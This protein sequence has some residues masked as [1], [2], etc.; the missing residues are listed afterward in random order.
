MGRDTG[1][2]RALA[3]PAR[4]ASGWPRSYTGLASRWLLGAGE[5]ARGVLAF[6]LITLGVLVSRFDM[7]RTV[8]R[9]RIRTQIARAGVQLLPMVLFLATALG[10]VVIGQTVALLSQVGAQHLI[11]TVMVTAVVREL[12]PL[13]AAFVVL[14]RIGTATVIDLGSSRALGEIE[15]LEALGIDPIHYL[16]VPRVVGM[17]LATF[18]LTVYFIMAAL[19]CG[20]LFAFIQDVPIKPGEYF[21]Q[22]A[23]AL[24]WPDFGLLLLKPLAFGSVIAVV[25]CYQG[26][27]RPLELREV[28]R[29]T[30]TAV[31]ASTIACVLLDVGFILVYLLV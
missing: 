2:R 22:L 5:T 27:A 16:V 4:L 12:G 23:R 31:V 14:L 10:F 13:I 25:T 29:V 26:L 30:T 24:D 8:V 9:P 15:A 19:F 3:A 1:F 17:A 21:R 7:A 6:G 18:A 28:S 11:G 20:Y